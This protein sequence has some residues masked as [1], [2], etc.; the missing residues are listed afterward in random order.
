MQNILVIVIAI[1]VRLI[2]S[3]P[4]YKCLVMHVT[5]YVDK[6]GIVCGMWY[7]VSGVCGAWCGVVWRGPCGWLPKPAT[8]HP[9]VL[10]QG[11]YLSVTVVSVHFSSTQCDPG[12]MAMPSGHLALWPSDAYITRHFSLAPPLAL[13]P[14]SP[15]SG[16]EP[17]V[18]LDF[19]S[20]FCFFC[21]L[22][23]SC[24]ETVRVFSMLS[25]S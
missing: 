21:F 23:S 1:V 16:I 8:P 10:P 4:K 20:F 18:S 24:R 9:R 5:L 12:H 7:G 14:A 25:S 15:F 13:A 2:Q 19:F 22:V 17:F 3:V 6:V 11:E